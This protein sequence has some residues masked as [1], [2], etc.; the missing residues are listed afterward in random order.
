MVFPVCTVGGGERPGFLYTIYPSAC[1]EWSPQPTH[2]TSG[3]LAQLS[4]QKP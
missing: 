4:R 2:K 1:Q 3:N